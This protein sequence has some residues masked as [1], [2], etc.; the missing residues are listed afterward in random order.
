[1]SNYSEVPVGDPQDAEQPI[2][3]SFEQFIRA[4]S[5]S[6]ERRIGLSADDLP[7]FGFDEFYPGDSA[8]LS[9]YREAV[10]ECSTALIANAGYPTMSFEDDDNA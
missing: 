8:Y 4:V 1:M 2:S 7:D 6:V 3:V 5:R 9:E 10:R